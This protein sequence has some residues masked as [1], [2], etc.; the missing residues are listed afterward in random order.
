[1]AS[2]YD[3]QNYFYEDLN[4][5]VSLPKFQRKLVWSRTEKE[6]FINTLHHGFPFGAILIYKY[7]DDDKISLIDGLQ[8]FTTIKD[9]QQNPENYIQF[10]E[11]INDV[12]LPLFNKNNNFNDVMISHVKHGLDSAIKE[13]IKY[14]NTNQSSFNTFHEI[15]KT[16]LEEYPTIIEDEWKRLSEIHDIIIKTLNSF[17]D[18]DKIKIP[19]I[20]FTGRV[21]DLATVFENLNRGGKKLSKY[22]V[23]AAQWSKYILK[24]S[25]LNYN[26]EILRLTIQRYNDLTVKREIEIEDYDEDKMLA[27]KEVN[28][29][30]FCYAYG[31]LISKEMP[32]FWDEDNEDQCN[33][34]GYSTLA[35]VFAKSNKDLHE[36]IDHFETLNSPGLI[37]N[38]V[39]QTLG[40]FHDINSV[41]RNRF[42]LPGAL[43]N[44]YFGGSVG[45]DFQLL[46]FFG[47][48]WNIKYGNIKE[49]KQLTP[50]PKHRLDYERVEKNLLVY[51]IF[52]VVSSKWG[53]SGDTKLDKIVLE[54]EDPYKY[55][56]SKDKFEAQLLNWHDDIV[57]KNSLNFEKVSRMLYTVLC[58]FYKN[59]F[60]QKKYDCEH[61]IPKSH[62]KKINNFTI[63]GGSI[64]N[65]MYLDI[66]NNR[67][68]GDLSLY[69]QLKPGQKIDGDYFS[70]QDYPSKE[71]FENIR[72]ELQSNSND[73]STVVS[74]IKNRGKDIINDLIYKLYSL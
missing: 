29:A 18:I 33:Q 24:L 48:L 13:Y 72:R 31:K 60:D 38:L 37:E 3:I 56:L 11:I 40:I 42:E 71:Q 4:N 7:E 32:V 51:Y 67:A 15:L 43:E 17:L 66:N 45:T 16:E 47:S 69:D 64:G 28:M 58:S 23:F 27:D 39:I 59:N 63:P 41:F 61:I 73:Y 53:G 2:Q 22:Q 14:Y 50:K 57:Q 9:F 62:L 5:K 54:N 1:M 65:L 74:T 44:N 25:D 52:D 36:L 19:T 20:E 6:N 70:F 46:S 34:I 12:L 49:N 21:S 68:K 10:D 55:S 8:R 30:E 35:I 26:R